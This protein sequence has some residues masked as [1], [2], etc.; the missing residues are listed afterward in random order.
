MFD[1]VKR[2]G[3]CTVEQCGL[4]EKFDLKFPYASMAKWFNWENNNMANFMTKN[5][6]DYNSIFFAYDAAKRTTK[7]AYVMA[8]SSASKRIRCDA[9][10]KVG[11]E[12][13]CDNVDGCIRKMFQAKTWLG[14]ERHLL[15]MGLGAQLDEDE[16]KYVTDAGTKTLKFLEYKFTSEADKEDKECKTY[17][18]RPWTQ[19]FKDPITDADPD[20]VKG[21]Q[22]AV[23]RTPI[24]D[25]EKSWMA[26][27]C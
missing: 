22:S 2:D 9:Y 11:K 8:P 26:D 15:C 19:L 5:F 14:L 1:L 17:Y 12:G 16:K 10:E 25:C 20:K 23:T 6:W 7:P 13:E 24:Y 18:P 21:P 3:G 27:T 4:G